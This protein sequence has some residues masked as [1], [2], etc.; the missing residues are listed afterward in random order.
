MARALR[1]RRLLPRRDPD[2]RAPERQG[3]RPQA[4]RS[5]RCPRSARTAAGASTPPRST[6]RS[7]AS[8]I[9]EAARSCSPCW[10]SSPAGVKSPAG[11]RPRGAVGR[12]RSRRSARSTSRVFVTSPPGRRA[13][14]RRRAGRDDPHRGRATRRSWT[15]PTSVERGRRAGPARRWRSRPTTPRAGGSTSTTRPPTGRTRS[16]STGRTAT[17]ADPASERVLISQD[18]LRAQPQRRHARLR[19]R[20]LPLHRHGRRRRRR[21]PARRARQRR[22][23]LARSWARSCAS[24]PPPTASARTRSRT[25]TRS[26]AASGAR[27]EIYAYGLRNPWRFSFDR[28]TGDLTIGDVGQNAVEEIDFVRR[29]RARARTS[30]GACSRARS[31]FTEGEERRGAIEPV[32]DATHA[33]G[34]CSITGGYV[35]RDP[36][37]ASCRGRYLVRRPVPRAAAVAELPAASRATAGSRCTSAVL[38]RRGRPGARLRALARRARSTV[39]SSDERSPTCA[40]PTR[41]R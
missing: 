36:A 10:R 41:A 38:V 30:A 31:R 3:D 23:P 1:V 15:S 9:D 19:A 12:G 11:P 20:R 27:G 29:A 26:S 14:V 8:S 18:G 35:V 21:R 40:R 25:T 32:I 24:I 4:A 6:G 39:S 22:R 13:R 34:N 33:D 17:A 2:G 7:I 16:P 28:T 37:L 5:S